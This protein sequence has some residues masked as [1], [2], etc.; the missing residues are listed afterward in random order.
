MD[1]KSKDMPYLTC[2]QQTIL[3]AIKGHTIARKSEILPLLN[4]AFIL[5]LAVGLTIVC[6]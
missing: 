4:G 6:G 2:K 5:K 1:S 3:K